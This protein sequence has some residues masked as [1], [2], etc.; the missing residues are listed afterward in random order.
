MFFFSLQTKYAVQTRRQT[1]SFL[2]GVARL[3]STPRPAR[4]PTTWIEDPAEGRSKL[5]STK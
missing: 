4:Y 2:G 1:E 3:K 5:S